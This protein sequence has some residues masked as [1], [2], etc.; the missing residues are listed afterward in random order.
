VTAITP[1]PCRRSAGIILHPTS[2]PGPYGIGDLGRTAYAWVNALVRARQTWW[3]VLP[4]GPT[5]YGDSPYQCFSA[6]AGNP[7]L[8][9]PEA[10]VEDGL[11][12]SHD[13]AGVSFP[14]ERVDFGAV[15]DFKNRLLARAWENFRSGTST[16]LRAPFEMFCRDHESWLDDFALFRALKDSQRGDSWQNWPLPLIQRQPEALDQ[17]SR[18]LADHIGLHRFRQ[19]LFFRQWRTLKQ[20]ANDQGLRLIGD[21]P[22]FVASDSAD[23]WANPDLFS[24]DDKGRPTVV[25][26][27]PPDYFSKTGQLWGNPLYN[28]ARLQ[29]TGYAWWVA[30]LRSSLDL[31][32]LVR[33]DHFRGFEAYWEIPAGKPTAEVGR[34]IKGPGP[35]LFET[36]RAALGK[37]PLVAEDLGFITPE[38][39][40]LRD[41]L[42]LPG[43]RVL[44]F[45]FG[46]DADNPYLPHHFEPNTVVYTGTHDNNTTRGWYE[47]IPPTEKAFLHRYLGHDAAEPAWDLIRL[48]WSSVADYA[49]APLQDILNLGEEA[50]MNLPGRPAGNWG[51]RFRADML[52]A[53]ILDR[54][55]ELTLLYSRCPTPKKV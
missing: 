20:Y 11:I 25:A 45:A 24:L 40:Q 54:L 27:V 16:T 37:L 48:A 33:I 41:E 36:L 2:L 35:E 3:Q 15:I 10:L 47:A 44:Q 8:V 22:I 42:A 50:R 1:P 30:R 21:I 55:A 53:P 39:E 17:A 34:W 9:S 6:F 14:P 38:V 5:G 19:F 49:L 32:D 52:T 18:E 43:M 13:L 4:L 12:S 31:V 51:W 28:W 46:D 7:C 23:V 26:G 29:Q